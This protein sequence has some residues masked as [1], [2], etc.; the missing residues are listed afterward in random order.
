MPG[1]GRAGGNGSSGE[2]VSGEGEMETT[3][4]PGDSVTFQG[5]RGLRVA[6]SVPNRPELCDCEARELLST[7]PLSACSK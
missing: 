1:S 3:W 4:L 7:M 6:I 2:G 5:A